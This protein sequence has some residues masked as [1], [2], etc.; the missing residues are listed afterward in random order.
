MNATPPNN[1]VTGG[2]LVNFDNAPQ[3][4]GN[5]ISVL[6]HDGTTGQTQTAFGI[7][8]GVVP[9]NTVTTFTG[10]DTTNAA[11]TGNKIN[12]VTQLNATGYSAFGHSW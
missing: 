11:I 1:L 7:A 8:L 10:S 3:I 2:I 4:T 9:T 6:R 12:G 5:D